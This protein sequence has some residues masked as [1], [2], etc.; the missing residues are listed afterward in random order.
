MPLS[1][2][3]KA[4]DVKSICLELPSHALQSWIVEW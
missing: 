3:S 2:I 4:E 1:N